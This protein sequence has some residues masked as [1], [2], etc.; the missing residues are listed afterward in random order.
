VELG[1]AH[2][3]RGYVFSRKGD[4][5][6]ASQHLRSARET[7]ENVNSPVN[8][9]NAY[10][11]LARVERLR[12]SLDEARDLLHRAVDLLSEAPEA[13]ILA[14]AHRELGLCEAGI[15]PIGAEKH[16][17][18]AIEL[19]ERSGEVPELVITYGYLGDLLREAG[20]SGAG[21]DSY[22]EGIAVLERT[23]LTG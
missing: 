17:K 2:L 9:A 14:W 8:Q 3:A 11:E 13:G 7:F 10:C 5:D 20:D 22:R 12:G 1:V 19:Y 23:L 16:Y 4:L 6:A 21:C 15:D 18:Q